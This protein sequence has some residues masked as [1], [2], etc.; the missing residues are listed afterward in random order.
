[1]NQAKI[2]RF[3]AILR[4][5]KGLTQADLAEK[6]SVSNKAVSKWETGKSLPDAD[7]ISDLCTLLGISI[8]DYFNG[9]IVPDD[10]YQNKAEQSI[11]A[12]RKDMETSVRK[13]RLIMTAFLVAS[14]LIVTVLVILNTYSVE[15]YRD[16]VSPGKIQGT[17]LLG[18]EL[19]DPEYIVV[20]QSM[21]VSKYHQFGQIS[22]GSISLI[23]NNYYYVVFDDSCYYIVY[24]TDYLEILSSD[25]LLKAQKISSVPMYINVDN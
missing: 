7:R 15:K 2:G 22:R 19:S 18:D 25:T 8:N 14:I 23:D 12:A 10:S 24:H 16:Y 3:I 6:M 13:S 21:N 9:E 5:E 1:M 20:D 4:K 11:L 17:F